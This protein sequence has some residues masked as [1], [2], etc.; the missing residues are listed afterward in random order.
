MALIMIL[1]DDLRKAVEAVNKADNITSTDID[2]LTFTTAG[3]LLQELGLI[4]G[5]ALHPD[6]LPPEGAN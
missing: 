6:D 1:E 3:L 2:Y 4:V 5:S